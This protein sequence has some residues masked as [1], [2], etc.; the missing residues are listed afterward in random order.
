[1]TNELKREVKYIK[2][3]GEKRAR[4]LN[5]LGIFTL[6]DLLYHI[7]RRYIDYSDPFPISYAPYD[8]MCAVKATVLETGVGIRIKSGRKLFR[9]TARDE[10]AT[11]TITFF[12]SEYTVKQLVPGKE[13][14]FWGKLGGS[15]LNRTMTTPLFIP[16]DAPLKRQAVYPLTAGLS[17]KQISTIVRNAFDI[18]GHLEDPIPQHILERY[19]LTDLDS[20]LRGVHFPK[21]DEEL[22]RS[23]DRLAFEEL[24]YLQL[25]MSMLN[26][27]YKKKTGI[28]VENID[29]SPLLKSLPYALT[30]AQNRA[31]SDIL[32]D[33]LKSTAMNRL[34]QGDVGSGKTIVAM[35]AMYC[36]K[37]NGYQSC[38]MAPTEILA[39]QHYESFVRTLCPLGVRVA[40]LTASVKGKQRKEVLQA[41]ESGEI[42]ILVGTH[43]ILSQEVTF[44]SLGLTVTDEQHR[45][46]V[47]QRNL[48]SLKG[49]DPHVLVMSATPIPR[50]LA[51][52]IYAGMEIS[53][54]DEMP[55]GRL[56]V[57]TYLVDST[58]RQRMYSFVDR[59]IKMGYQ[60]YVVLP[61][62]DENEE[63]TDMQSVIKY[64]D[65]TVKKLLPDAR[66]GILHGRMKAGEK[67][68][69][70]G[71]FVRGELDILCSTTV[72]EVGV[73]VPNAVIMII[74]NAERYGLSAMHQLRGRVGRN[75]IQSY[76]ILVSDKKS[77]PI[78][79][80][81]RF[82]AANNSGFEVSQYD[83]EHRGPGDF[84]GSAQ[85]GLPVM[86]TANLVTDLDVMRT[87]REAANALIEESPDLA[88]YPLI[89]EKCSRMFGR[90]TL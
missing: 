5:R 69:V 48:I 20:A 41:L 23:I 26:A 50:T 67:E 49:D 34:L 68:R 63:M 59:H 12:N 87:S 17:A 60:T 79:D 77:R 80:R 83:L 86:K 4:Q 47:G 37:L 28:R 9:V 57:K 38:M 54:I 36:M 46:G 35:A 39:N 13:Y 14:I 55:N 15:M 31:I 24:F 78:Q 62:I 61:A 1:M 2:G 56:P 72:I 82:L 66:V 81:L 29:I 84:F 52:I 25:G 75:D 42:D 10:S 27:S 85:H 90:V 88:G 16:A 19:S 89:R 6:E 43:A 40:L 18:V 32:N 71:R 64:C 65:E 45:F 21:S 3:V 22:K 7:P 73:D 70:M 44:S 30:N 53:V 11:L 74:E 33:L 8:E 76:C 51:M 58:Y